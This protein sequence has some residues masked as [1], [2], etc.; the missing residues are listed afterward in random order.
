MPFQPYLPGFCAVDFTGQLLK[1]SLALFLLT[2]AGDGTQS[3]L[4]SRAAQRYSRTVL[5]GLC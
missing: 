3:M 4:L 2:L 5:V 1:R